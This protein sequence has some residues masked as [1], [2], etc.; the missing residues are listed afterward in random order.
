MRA[1]KSLPI[2]TIEPFVRVLSHFQALLVPQFLRVAQVAHHLIVD[3]HHREANL[4]HRLIAGL[5]FGLDLAEQV[6]AD[7]RHDALV[8]RVAHHRVR[9][10][11]ARLTVCEQGG[12]VSVEG[13][14]YSR[15]VG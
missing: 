1:K 5:L 7:S 11:A 14:L 12:V 4:E 2:I 6:L 10:S 8:F 15:R 13:V 3:L 9:F